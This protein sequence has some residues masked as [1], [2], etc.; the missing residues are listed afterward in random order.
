MRKCLSRKFVPSVLNIDVNA[1][2]FRSKIM[3]WKATVA[4]ISRFRMERMRSR[5][6]TSS[7]FKKRLPLPIERV[8]GGEQISCESLM[9]VFD[10]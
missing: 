8:C 1:K 3:K 6:Q 10:S 7:R 9:D 5:M 2:L 4:Q